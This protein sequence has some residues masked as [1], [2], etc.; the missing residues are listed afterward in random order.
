MATNSTLGRGFPTL[1]VLFGWVG[2]TPRR[3]RIAVAA[4]AAIVAGPPLWWSIQLAGLPDIGEPFDVA[5]FRSFT[6]PEERNADP[7]YLRASRSLRRWGVRLSSSGGRLDGLTRWAAADPELR[8]WAEENREAL[9]LY[10]RASERPDCLGAVPRFTG[11]HQDLWGLGIPLEQLGLLALLE[12]SR[13]EEKGDMAG[14]WGWYRAVLRTIHHVGRHGTVERRAIAQGWYNDLLARLG[15][16][17]ADPRTAPALLRRALDDAVACE[18]LAPSEAYT[19]KA[20]YL[21]VDRLLEAPDAPTVL[22]P[23]SWSAPIPSLAFSLTREQTEALYETWRRWRR[24]P[25]RSRRA[26]RLAIANW[27]AFEESPPA[28]RPKA[29]P[30]PWLTFAFHPLGPDAPTR[31]RALSPRALAGWLRSTIDANFFLG[32]WGWSAVRA[33][34][35]SNRR[36]LLILLAG[37]LFRRDH[38]SDPTS[39]ESLVGPYLK[40]LPEAVDEGTEEM[41]PQGGKPLQ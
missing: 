20:E 14:A 10:R 37:E 18:S 17:S 32:S 2:K 11:Y 12:G 16:W 7:L 23:G 25:E 19:L 8:G 21:D 34:E 27:V 36:K 35:Q 6:I 39:S 38:G 40:T 15:T 1:N 26:I 24:E 5:A 13:L 3:K 9:D 28:S 4:L 22:P 33:T 29:A 41:I 31:A 30:V